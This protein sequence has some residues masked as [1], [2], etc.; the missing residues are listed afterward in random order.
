MQC[1]G[2]VS[3]ADSNFVHLQIN[4]KFSSKFGW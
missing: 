3:N 2:S 1:P 4:E